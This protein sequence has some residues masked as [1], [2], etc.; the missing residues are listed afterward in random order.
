MYDAAIDLVATGHATKTIETYTSAWKKWQAFIQGRNIG[1]KEITETNMCLFSAWLASYDPPLSSA[2]IANYGSEILSYMKIIGQP[3]P[4]RNEWN[5][6]A[7]TL[8]SLKKR[9]APTTADGK[10]AA[11]SIAQ[12]L[13]IKKQCSTSEDFNMLT[14]AGIGIMGLHRLGGNCHLIK[15]QARR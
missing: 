5:H 1:E 12:L 9:D 8:K 14:L 10:R 7:A 13:S 3:V 4:N 11:L 15:G 6:Y 2:T